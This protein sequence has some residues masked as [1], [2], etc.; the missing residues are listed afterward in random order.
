MSAQENKEAEILPL[1][2]S[3]LTP[4]DML[5]RA[6]TSGAGIE[7]LT[8]LMDLQERWDKNQARKAFDDA[9]SAA[10]IEI[11]IIIKNRQVGFDAKAPGKSSTNYRHED[12]AEIA[13]TVDPILGKYGLSYRFRTTSLPNEPVTVTCIV[14]H[15]LGHSEENVLCAGRDETGN[16]NS[17]QALG[18][19]LTYLQRYALKA[20]LGLAASNDDDGMAS[21][22]GGEKLKSVYA[23]KPIAAEIKAAFLACKSIDQLFALGDEKAPLIGTLN[24]ICQDD[25]RETFATHRKNLRIDGKYHGRPA[26]AIDAETGEVADKV[27][28]EEDGERP[29]T[30]ADVPA[31]PLDIPEPLKRLTPQQEALWL[32]LLKSVAAAAPDTQTMMDLQVTHMSPAQQRKVSAPA[33]LEAVTIFRKRVQELTANPVFNAA[34]W[35]IGAF[36]GALSGAETS[37]QIAH[38]KDTM[39]IPRKDD[40][41]TDQWREAVKMYHERLDAISPKNILGG[42]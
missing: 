37:K 28:W 20:A 1:V 34:T 18:S 39:L 26:E 27:I 33:W 41:S 36:A 24:I 2:R 32:D 11:P 15:R 7:V 40:L 19:T 9:L 23:S 10:K 25:I 31:D 17:I 16:K 30:A 4:M 12:L 3:A 8:K 22:N 14:S 38:I 5:D 35:L 29:A 6:I 13:R 42:G 21:G